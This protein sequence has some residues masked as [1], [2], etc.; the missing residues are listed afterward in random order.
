VRK[1]ERET[2]TERDREKETEREIVCVTFH[3]VWEGSLP[4]ILP[5]RS[6]SYPF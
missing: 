4:V 3:H 2:Q 6:L 1:R 5:E